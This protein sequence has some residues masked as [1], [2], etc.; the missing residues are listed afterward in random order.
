MRLTTENIPQSI[1]ALRA[2]PG[3]GKPNAYGMTY[4]VAQLA[5]GETGVSQD[6]SADSVL[7]MHD[8]VP[9]APVDAKSHHLGSPRDFLGLLL[10]FFSCEV[11]AR[12]SA[13]CR[14][15]TG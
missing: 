13:A 7:P 9:E 14:I 2:E 5:S 15:E 11:K 6:W 1:R 3:S 4:P 12:V 8:L 10:C